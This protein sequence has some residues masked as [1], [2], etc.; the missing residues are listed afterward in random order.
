MRK[1]SSNNSY[2]MSLG[3]N[4]AISEAREESIEDFGFTSSKIKIPPRLQRLNVE[5]DLFA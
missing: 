3:E 1:K 4:G 5:E 2:P